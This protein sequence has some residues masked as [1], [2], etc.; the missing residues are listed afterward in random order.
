M[1][2]KIQ[3]YINIIKGKV[4][5]TIPCQVATRFAEYLHLDAIIENV[6]ILIEALPN[7]EDSFLSDKACG[8]IKISFR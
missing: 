7:F 1:K 2:N 5:K 4:F 8:D 3:N 6:P